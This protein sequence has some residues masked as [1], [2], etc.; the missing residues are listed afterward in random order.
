MENL[1]P[2]PPAGGGVQAIRVPAQGSEESSFDTVGGQSDDG[3]PQ[4]LDVYTAFHEM[5]NRLGVFEEHYKELLARH[6]EQHN[7]AVQELLARQ[8]ETNNTLLQVLERLEQIQSRLAWSQG[9]DTPSQ[10]SIPG[11]ESLDDDEVLEREEMR[12]CR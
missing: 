10:C 5:Q 6:S 12:I 1:S 8:A 7:A 11:Y 9:S 4:H 3:P 2:G